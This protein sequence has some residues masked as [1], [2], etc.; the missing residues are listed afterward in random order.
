[1]FFLPRPYCTGL[2]MVLLLLTTTL[3]VRILYVFVMLHSSHCKIKIIL[4][5]RTAATYFAQTV[6]FLHNLNLHLQ[7]QV[8]LHYYWSFVQ[9]IMLFRHFTYDVQDVSLR[10]GLG[11][12]SE[13]ISS[14]G[15]LNLQRNRFRFKKAFLTLCSTL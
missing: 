4:I 10:I 1:M 15:R 14:E 5:A 6:L 13:S 8:T 3:G 12:I 11:C 7:I 2:L 9:K